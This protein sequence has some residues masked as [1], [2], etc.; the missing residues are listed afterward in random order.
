MHPSEKISRTNDRSTLPPAPISPQL[1][2]LHS[3]SHIDLWFAEDVLWG[4]CARDVKAAAHVVAS[5]LLRDTEGETPAALARSGRTEAIGEK[6]RVGAH[7]SETTAAAALFEKK[8]DLTES[9]TSHRIP[10]RSGPA[11]G[12]AAVGRR[13]SVADRR[14][15]GGADEGTS[16]KNIGTVLAYRAR[17]RVSSVVLHFLAK[18]LHPGAFLFLACRTNDDTNG[19]AGEKRRGEDGSQTGSGREGPGGDE[20]PEPLRNRRAGPEN[21]EAGS[22]GDGRGAALWVTDESVPLLQGLKSQWGEAGA[23]ASG[24]MVRDREEASSVIRNGAAMCCVS[25]CFGMKSGRS[26]SCRVVASLSRCPPFCRTKTFEEKESLR[27]RSSVPYGIFSHQIKR[28]WSSGTEMLCL[29]LLSPPLEMNI[30]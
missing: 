14:A 5:A 21:A 9:A 3:C 2:R 12:E 19:F 11:Q 27:R 24:P 4:L 7:A 8:G 10:D 30:L 29:V 1:E 16:E 25:R 18:G 22:Q 20:H 28:K 26:F 13:L 23:L 6:K 17:V 15:A